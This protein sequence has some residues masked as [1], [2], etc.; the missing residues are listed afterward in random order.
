MIAR[1][2]EFLWKFN[3][4][5][6]MGAG[7]ILYRV[8]LAAQTCLE[9]RGLGLALTS[10]PFGE[11]GQAWLVKSPDGFDVSLYREAAN[12]ILS[13]YFN[14]FAM[15]RSNL[16]FPPCWNR[17]PKTRTDAPLTFGKVLNYRDER[18]V[19]D[20][21]YLW[22]PNRHKELVTLAQA[23]Y[24][25][26]EE[27]Y[28]TGCRVL[29][30]S[31]FEQCPYPMGVNW[32]S[33]LE[34][35]MRLANW[36][37]TWHLLIS[38]S[39]F[40][41]KSGIEFRRRWLDSI[42]QHCHFIS[43][44]LSR[45]SSAN[46]H[47]LGELMGL[48]VASITWPMWQESLCWRTRAMQEFEAEAIKQNAPDGVNREQALWYQHEVADMMLLCGLIGRANGVEFS[49][50]YWKRLEA[51]LEFIASIM[52]VRGNVPM[53]GDADDAMIIRW[54]PEVVIT[55]HFA[56]EIDSI[57]HVKKF[58]VYRSLLATGAVLF[59]RADFKAKAGKFDEKSRWMLGNMAEKTFNAL[60]KE[61]TRLPVRRS[62][63]EGGYYIL[64][65]GFEKPHEVR[66]LADAGPLGYLSIAAHGHSDA[67]S[68]T[69]SVGGCELL[70]DPGTFSFHTQ[71]KWRDYFRGTSAH[72]T[73]RID[74]VDQSVTG[75]NFLWSRHA[76]ACCEHFDIGLEQDVLVASHDGYQ[77]L[78]DPV[79]HRRE[80]FYDKPTR[81][82]TVTDSLDCRQSH[83]MEIFWH[84]AEGCEVRIEERIVHARHGDVLLRMAMSDVA[85]W[86]ELVVGQEEPPLGWVSRQ[87][88]VKIPS[89]SVVWRMVI[90]GTIS[91]KT[92][93]N[94]H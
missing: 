52:D 53:I 58:N 2:K 55:P 90:H 3:R 29:L 6:T 16:G 57:D 80:L 78:K 77:R 36:V 50:I 42:F 22:E 14:I 83:E 66:I 46:N 8:Q 15:Q 70:I 9:Q 12:G 87:F 84:F 79:T 41:G 24:L 62:F 40:S 74:R 76:K 68:F 67:L 25:T 20:I 75:G 69:L 5:R 88:D 82:L 30:D 73:V 37:I 71:K 10:E 32:T 39:V 64:G 43:G 91:L 89:A 1:M 17:D 49:E 34:H 81:V 72:N 63:P 47:L 51:M 93:I 61:D 33:S 45:H 54:I 26:G 4:L 28:A 7:E 35:A 92:I 86:P 44:N 59:N 19:G 13:G 18:L 31:W 27:K 94:L 23:Y 48:F 65:D 85:W 56:G 21:K 60:P 38:S 11:V